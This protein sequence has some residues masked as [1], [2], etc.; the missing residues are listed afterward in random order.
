MCKRACAGRTAWGGVQEETGISLN[1]VDSTETFVNDIVNGRWD[2]VLQTT[3]QL[4]LP[5]KIVI[6]LY[7]Q[8]SSSEAA[9]PRGR[10]G[11]GG[12][13]AAC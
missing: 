5:H 3:A 11:G 4:K 1:V 2:I 10:G 7:E 8:A 12:A 9:I 13:V 6:D